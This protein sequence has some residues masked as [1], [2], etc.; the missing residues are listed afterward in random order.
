MNSVQRYKQCRQLRCAKIKCSNKTQ[1]V[2]KYRVF[3]KHHV[4]ECVH[5]YTRRLLITAA[6]PVLEIQISNSRSTQQH[7][8][9]EI[10]PLR[11]IQLVWCVWVNVRERQK[12]VVLDNYGSVGQIMGYLVD[13]I[14]AVTALGRSCFSA[15]RCSGE[16]DRCFVVKPKQDND[17][18]DLSALWGKS[19]MNS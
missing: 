11:T 12:S 18:S 17:D 15:W 14:R 9:G 8:M 3:K 4:G 7:R 10:G 6:V 1:T 5:P 13:W 16:K 2:Q 19:S